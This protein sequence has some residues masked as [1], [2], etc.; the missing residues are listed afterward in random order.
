MSEVVLMAPLGLEEEPIGQLGF[1]V[2]KGT[3]FA[4]PGLDAARVALPDSCGPQDA[5]PDIRGFTCVEDTCAF[6]ALLQPPG[7]QHLALTGEGEVVVQW[8]RGRE[9]VEWRVPRGANGPLAP[10]RLV[11]GVP[12]AAAARSLDAGT[13]ND[14]AFL[15][16][17]LAACGSCSATV[18][19]HAATAT[20]APG[21]IEMRWAG[22]GFRLVAETNGYNRILDGDAIQVG[23]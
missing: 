5:P 1:A 20:A 15:A 3:R 9:W 14:A 12:D 19:Q 2:P 8:V 21:T 6:N 16:P 7:G 11:T 23:R 18:A 4:A 13:K 17:F 10:S 22:G